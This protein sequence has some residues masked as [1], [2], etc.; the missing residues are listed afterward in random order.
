MRRDLIFKI[1]VQTIQLSPQIS[2]WMEWCYRPVTNCSYFKI[3]RKTEAM[4]AVAECTRN[5]L[6]W[7]EKGVSLSKVS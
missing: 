5:A 2:C 4:K 6:H 3:V 7:G 1:L